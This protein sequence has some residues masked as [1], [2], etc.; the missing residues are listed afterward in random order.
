MGPRRV[1]QQR[2]MTI[3]NAVSETENTNENENITVDEEN[4]ETVISNTIDDSKKLKSN[5]WAYAKKI[6][7][8]TAQCLQCKK[9]N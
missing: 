7:S 2:I 4:N 1:R 6:S 3:N 9:T 5:V 8:K